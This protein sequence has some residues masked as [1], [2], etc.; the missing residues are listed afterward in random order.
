MSLTGRYNPSRALGFSLSGRY[1]VLFHMVSDVSLSGNFRQA[2]AQGLFSIVHRPG[3]GYS[4][5]G[6][7]RSR[8]NQH[9]ACRDGSRAPA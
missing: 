7:N 9:D 6:V 4:T 5:P 3:L 1:D 8:S 2:W